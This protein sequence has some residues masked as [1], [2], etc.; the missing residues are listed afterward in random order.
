MNNYNF[1]L[2]G[3]D[4][5]LSSILLF[6][7]WEGKDDAYGEIKTCNARDRSLVPCF[8]LPR[9][10]WGGVWG[11]SSHSR[12]CKKGAR[13][14]P[15]ICALDL[16]LLRSLTRESQKSSQAYRSLGLH[17]TCTKLV[18]IAHRPGMLREEAPGS[19]F[20]Q[21]PQKKIETA[22]ARRSQQA[23]TLQTANGTLAAVLNHRARTRET[24]FACKFATKDMPRIVALSR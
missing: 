16:H 17:A 5:I 10:C 6:R 3:C 4:A 1:V 11:C 8:A 19:D 23:L 9:L 12:T 15:T 18:R 7:D 21:H 20:A 2:H 13:M 22:E 24:S 14:L